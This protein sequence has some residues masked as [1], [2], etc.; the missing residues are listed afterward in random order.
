MGVRLGGP[1]GALYP[2]SPSSP[3]LLPRRF[4]RRA[5][6]TIP[7]LRKQAAHLAARWDDPFEDKLVGDKLGDK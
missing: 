3:C 2:I 6:C 1:P 7:D 5:L 4:P